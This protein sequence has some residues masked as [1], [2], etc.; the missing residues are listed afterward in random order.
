VNVAANEFYFTSQFGGELHSSLNCAPKSALLMDYFWVIPRPR[1]SRITDAYSLLL[2]L[3]TIRLACEICCLYVFISSL[4]AWL[5]ALGS[6][7]GFGF[8]FTS[9]RIAADLGPWISVSTVRTAL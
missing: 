2:Q 8:D 4:S 3:Q 1:S 7:L 5:S 9:T 6:H